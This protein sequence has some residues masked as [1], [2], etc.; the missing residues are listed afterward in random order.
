MENQII[1]VGDLVEFP[2]ANR[3]QILFGVV[4][5]IK[6]FVLVFQDT[7]GVTHYI[8]RQVAERET[9]L[10]AKFEDVCLELEEVA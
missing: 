4:F 8:P 6:A 5:A 9:K 3:K 10:V 2:T 7:N 1:N